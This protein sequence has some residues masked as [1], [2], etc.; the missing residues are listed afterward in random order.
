MT[1]HRRSGAICETSHVP[2]RTPSPSLALKAISVI[3]PHTSGTFAKPTFTFRMASRCS[4][5]SA[6]RGAGRL[7]VTK[8]Q[9]NAGLAYLRNARRAFADAGIAED[10]VLCG[11]EIVETLVERGD[12]VA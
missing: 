8:G 12:T 11:L 2:L 5:T 1:R 9:V 3:A 7:L 10:A 6:A 4:V